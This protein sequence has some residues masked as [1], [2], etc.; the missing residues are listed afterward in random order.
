M[1]DEELRVYWY[2]N[3]TPWK[4][5]YGVLEFGLKT[6][7]RENKL[8]VLSQER[9]FGTEFGHG[10]LQWRRLRTCCS[11]QISALFRR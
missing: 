4:R 10:P 9:L 7:K 11:L 8:E 2:Y 6:F 3:L 1:N 5:V